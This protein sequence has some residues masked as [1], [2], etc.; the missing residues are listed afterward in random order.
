MGITPD[1]AA[2]P[3]DEE[4]I[5][6]ED[7]GPGGDATGDPVV[8]GA[9]RRVT[10][11]LRFFVGAAVRQILQV[12]N[13]PAGFDDVDLSGVV[14]GDLLEYDATSKSFKPGAGGGGLTEG[15]HQALRQ[16]IHFIDQGPTNGFTSGAYLETLPAGNLFSTSE[17]WWESATKLKKIVSLDTTWVGT[18]ITA[19]VWKV[20][21]TDGSTVLG[22]VTDA[23]T[24]SGI[25]E[26]TR[27]R[28][29]A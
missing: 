23:I 12:K 18:R 11:S 3:S 29:I 27:T 28:T 25:M 26:T 5:Q 15:T 10:N 8:E 7:R 17:I 20:Y 24:Y 16:L 4:E 1:Q 21:D 9:L 6:L 13:P 14:D 19:E 2:G 22:T